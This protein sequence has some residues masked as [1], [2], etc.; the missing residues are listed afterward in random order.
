M[1]LAMG[2]AGKV[3]RR[4]LFFSR[5]ISRKS[6]TISARAPSC[7]ASQIA[8]ANESPADP[9]DERNC[10]GK[11]INRTQSFAG[12]FASIREGILVSGPPGAA[13]IRTHAT[14]ILEVGA[15]ASHAAFR[16]VAGVFAESAR[17]E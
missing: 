3:A 2:V 16:G 8:F 1:A 13:L 9:G 14:A 6:P 4:P 5:I 15:P 7:G 17:R 10:A 11:K 12:E